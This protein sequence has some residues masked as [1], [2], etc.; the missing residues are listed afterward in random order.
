[1]EL[2]WECYYKKDNLEESA[3]ILTQ[4]TW[5][6]MIVRFSLYDNNFYC[7][8]KIRHLTSQEVLFVT[9]TLD[10]NEHNLKLKPLKK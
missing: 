4:G 8:M 6:V 7:T 1:M 5:L 2:H 9:S 3:A 10:K